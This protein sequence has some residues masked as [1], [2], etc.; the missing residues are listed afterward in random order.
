MISLRRYLFSSFILE[1]NE[2]SRFLRNSNYKIS[3][4]L[5]MV[6]SQ[7]ESCVTASNW[8]CARTK[9]VQTKSLAAGLAEVCEGAD[10]LGGNKDVAGVAKMYV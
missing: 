3:R 8:V 4:Y 1:L 2:N 7:R 6:L 10:E 5:Y 9:A